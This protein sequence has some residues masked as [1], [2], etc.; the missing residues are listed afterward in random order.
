MSQITNIPNNYMFRNG[1]IVQQSYLPDGGQVRVVADGAP[2]GVPYYSA[3]PPLEGTGYIQ[4]DYKESNTGPGTEKTSYVLKPQFDYFTIQA[5][6]PKL[7]KLNET[8][9][10]ILI[11]FVVACLLMAI[12]TR[13]FVRRMD[14]LKDQVENLD[15]DMND[16]NGDVVT[17]ENRVDLLETQKIALNARISMLEGK[18]NL[19]EN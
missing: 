18:N 13:V 4:L 3:P 5:V 9:G 19:P 17:L 16:E 2:S 8:V 7:D 1:A 14:K 10:N 12:N 6:Q 15:F 11:G